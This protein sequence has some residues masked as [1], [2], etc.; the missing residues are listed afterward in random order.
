M[1]VLS[2]TWLRL[3]AAANIDLRTFIS[4]EGHTDSGERN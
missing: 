3:V 1:L 4:E 2:F